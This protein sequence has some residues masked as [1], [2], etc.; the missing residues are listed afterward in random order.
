MKKQ[1]EEQEREAKELETQDK[2]TKRQAGK[3]GRKLTEQPAERTR[4]RSTPAIKSQ[5]NAMVSLSLSVSLVSSL[6]P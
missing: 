4:S 1:L 6:F 3:R 2:A 5:A